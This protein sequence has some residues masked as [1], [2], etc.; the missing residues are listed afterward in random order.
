MRIKDLFV[1]LAL[2][3]ILLPLILLVFPPAPVHATSITLN[4]ASSTVGTSVLISG[5]GFAGHLATIYW[6]GQ[7]VVTDVPISETGKLTY[8]LNVPHAC[9]GDHI[10][11]VNDDSHWASSTA[12]VTFTVLPQIEVRPRIGRAWTNIVIIGNGFATY[13]KDIK[14]TWDGNVLVGSSIAA[15]KLGKWSINLD[16][17]DTTKGEHFIGAFS[18]VTDAAE[19]AEVMFIVSPLAKVEPVSGSVGTEIT[20]NGF[21][22]RI[23]EDGITITYD[24]E[25]I[26]CNIVAEADG[27]WSTTLDIPASTQGYHTIGV[28]GS[29]FTPKGVVPSTDFEVIPQIE[30]QPASGSKGTQV[31]ITGTGFAKDEAITFTFDTMTLDTAA[32]T[33]DTGTFSA[34]LEVPQSK[35]KEHTIT[36]TGSDGNSAQAIFITEKTPPSAPQLLSP[37]QGAKLEIF[38]SVGDVVLGTAKYL[39]R[40]VDY[41]RGSKQAGLW[42][43]LATFDWS[44]VA[45]SNGVSYILQVARANDF[46]SPVLAREGLVSPDYTLSEEDIL[47]SGSY[48]WRIKAVDDVGNESPW[49]EVWKFEVISMSSQVLIL[50]SIIPVLFIAVLIF[51]ILTWRVNRPN[52]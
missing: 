38:D 41:L 34:I 14:I 51:G 50:S 42:P 39:I 10:I 5:E 6:D 9:K 17:T 20:I 46:S 2:V 13:E 36:A 31:T 4:P 49:S 40:I 43:A 12:S 45:D 23:G 27:S 25:I 24:G 33:D 30:P 48:S 44:E 29:S 3:T 11:R 16:I 32:T 22:F 37:E 19:V 8:N 21:G 35:G 1:A 15:D 47:T 7:V 52:P 18:S 28:F 26:K